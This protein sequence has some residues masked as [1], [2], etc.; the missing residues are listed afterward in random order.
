MIE[1]Y[2][3]TIF[4]FGFNW[5]PQGFVPCNGALLNIQQNTA[6]Y[7]LLGTI[8]GGNGQQ[9][10][11]VPDL[12]GR[13]IIGQG[14]GAGLT[15][16][17]IGQKDGSEAT[18]LTLNQLPN[19]THTA[20]FTGNSVTVKA[21]SGAGAA[22][23]PGGRNTTLASLGSGALYNGVA[24]DTALN[25]GGGAVTG[26][27]VNAAIGG[28]LPFTNMQPFQVLNYCIVTEGIYPSRP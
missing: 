26:T 22:P 20:V 27:V 13:T 9:T 2:L 14:N 15:P 7:S 28:G 8:Y 17:Q 1:A 23:N 25:V 4:A 12:Q 24:P 18:T 10:F 3:G 16:R 21:N 6:L 19:H 5:A 11:G